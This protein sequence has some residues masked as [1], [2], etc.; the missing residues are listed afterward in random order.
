MR[1][2]SDQQLNRS[3]G[4]FLHW[5]PEPDSVDNIVF[6]DEE[7]HT[8]LVRGVAAAKSN[9]REEARF[10]LHRA[11]EGELS[12]K[13]RIQAWRYL[14][15]LADDPRQQ[16]VYIESILAVDPTAGA[17]QRDLAVLKG[18]LDPGEI[19]DPEKPVPAAATLP[20]PASARSFICPLCGSA[21]VAFSP[22]GQS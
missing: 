14:A 1:Q 8:R 4:A 3:D 21:R 2:R 17:A 18:L 13:D 20:G 11:L 7:S 6:D 5:K 22:D 10:F 15:R 19:I 16:R 9:S 12:V